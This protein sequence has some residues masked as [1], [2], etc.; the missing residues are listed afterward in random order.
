[1]KAIEHQPSVSGNIYGLGL[2]QLTLTRRNR[3]QRETE[4]GNL[5]WREMN[6]E[7]VERNFSNL[8]LSDKF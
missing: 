7:W 1:M 6:S 8:Q 4:E 3:A 2:E 5:A